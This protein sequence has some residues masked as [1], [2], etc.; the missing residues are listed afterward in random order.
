[1]TKSVRLAHARAASFPVGSSTQ[2]RLISPAHSRAPALLSWSSGISRVHYAGLRI[3]P[4][5]QPG[6]LQGRAFGLAR[7]A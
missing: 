4:I 6:L 5:C 2:P 1:M 3:M 7:S